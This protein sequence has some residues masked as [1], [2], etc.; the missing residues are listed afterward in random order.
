MVDLNSYRRRIG[1]FIAVPNTSIFKSKKSKYDH[2]SYSSPLQI[3]LQTNIGT[4]TFL[5][6]MMW[7][8]L[9]CILSFHYQESNYFLEKSMYRSLLHQTPETHLKIN[10]LINCIT[11]YFLEIQHLHANNHSSKSFTLYHVIFNSLY[12]T[13]TYGNINCA[14]EGGSHGT[15]SYLIGNAGTHA[16]NGNPITKT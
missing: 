11:N 4:S 2:E 5:R 15:C 6:N 8:A 3:K 1:T 14:I 9:L 7:I 12:F 10:I 16:Y 13:A